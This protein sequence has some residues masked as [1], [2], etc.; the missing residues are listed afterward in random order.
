MNSIHRTIWTATLALFAAGMLGCGSAQPET[1][2]ADEGDLPVAKKGSTKIYD[3]WTDPNYTGDKI[4]KVL[5]LG[6]A[7]DPAVVE[8]FETAMAEMVSKTG[9]EAVKASSVISD[10][11]RQNEPELKKKVEEAGYTGV[12]VTRLVSVDS[13][14]VANAQSIS[15]SG[16]PFGSY[17]QQAYS[18]PVSTV[19]QAEVTAV[20]LESVLYKVPEA[21]MV[22]CGTTESF[23]PSPERRQRLFKEIGKL[24]VDSLK[25]AGVLAVE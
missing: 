16:Q 22:W 4:G 14:Y 21:E 17:Y 6:I 3:A 24:M 18:G 2:T 15:L 9:V 11:D 13:K 20:T 7:D 25:T 8:E 1:N 10:A 12:L 5:V 23:N 19:G